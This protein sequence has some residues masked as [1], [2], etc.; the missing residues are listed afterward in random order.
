VNKCEKKNG[1]ALFVL[2]GVLKSK[3]L[4]GGAFSWDVK[5]NQRIFSGS[6]KLQDKIFAK[7]LLLPNLCV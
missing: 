3:A 6:L 2:D 7:H 4:K 1:C 5:N